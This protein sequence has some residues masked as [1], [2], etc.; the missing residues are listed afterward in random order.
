MRLDP[1]SGVK[2]DEGLSLAECYELCRQIQKAH[3][4]TY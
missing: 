3:S 2:L 1:A 4:R